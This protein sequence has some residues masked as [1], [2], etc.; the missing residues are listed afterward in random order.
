M[1]RI[2]AGQTSQVT[3]DICLIQ[4]PSR[5]AFDLCILYHKFMTHPL[6]ATVVAIVGI[7]LILSTAMTVLYRSTRNAAVKLA[8]SAA[9]P[10][11]LRA[12]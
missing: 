9:Y 10:Q 7:G 6:V 2:L 3:V 8:N 1:Q 5:T 4:S 11:N 12:N